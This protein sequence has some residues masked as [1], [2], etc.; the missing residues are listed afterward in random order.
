[1]TNFTGPIKSD[2]PLIKIRP[3]GGAINKK[4]VLLIDNSITTS[5]LYYTVLFGTLGALGCAV[6]LLF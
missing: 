5:I 3:I 4:S 6:S 2:Q 1:M